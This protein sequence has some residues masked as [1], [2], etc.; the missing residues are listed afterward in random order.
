MF[1]VLFPQES[2]F[3]V[4]GQYVHCPVSL[5]KIDCSVHIVKHLTTLDNNISSEW[6]IEQCIETVHVLISETQWFQ[7]LSYLFNVT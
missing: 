7:F 2:L 6:T 4:A 1:Y 5:I 3:R